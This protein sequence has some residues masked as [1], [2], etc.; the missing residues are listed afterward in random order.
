MEFYRSENYYK[1]LVGNALRLL[2]KNK[3]TFRQCQQKNPKNFHYLK[4]LETLFSDS[5]MERKI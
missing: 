1:L 3:V 5:E 4:L 2:M